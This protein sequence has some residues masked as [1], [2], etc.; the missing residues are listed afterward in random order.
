MFIKWLTLP[1]LLSACTEPVKWSVMYMCIRMHIYPL[2]YRSTILWL[3]CENWSDSV[4]F[5]LL[6]SKSDMWGLSFF[7][8]A[9]FYRSGCTKPG[10]WAV[11]YL[12]TITIDFVIY[13][14][15]HIWVC[16]CSDSVVYYVYHLVNAGHQLWFWLQLRTRSIFHVFQQLYTLCMCQII[17]PS[18]TDICVTRIVSV[19]IK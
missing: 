12:C 18:F 11:T 15:R 2:F 3:E 16:N 10:K 1:L 9:I 14:D 6:F 13:Y 7:N 17:F 8:P 5:V 19:L 4:I